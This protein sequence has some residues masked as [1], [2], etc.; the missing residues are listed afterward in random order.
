MFH[1][2]LNDDWWI[3]PDENWKKKWLNKCSRCLNRKL[4]M[5][6]YYSLNN[7]L[8]VTL[9][10]TLALSPLSSF[11]I[12]WIQT[13]LTK[14]FFDNN[15]KFVFRFTFRINSL[16]LYEPCFG[17]WDSRPSTHERRTRNLS[18]ST[19]RQFVCGFFC[20][21]WKL[22]SHY[23]LHQTIYSQKIEPSGRYGIHRM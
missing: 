2:L 5:V 12:E 17:W 22:M 10:H 19:F 4:K 11:R 14:C 7:L 1:F 23:H 6:H 16:L 20:W 9:L 21:W 18:F 8:S 13:I 15:S 3:S